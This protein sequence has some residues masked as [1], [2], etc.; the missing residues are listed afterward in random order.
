M[1]GATEI[2]TAP[3]ALQRPDTSRPGPWDNDVFVYRA[4]KNGT[5]SRLATFPRAGVPTVARMKDG[6]L[7]A[8]HQYFPETGEGFDKVAVHFSADE[9]KTWTAART[10]G[11]TGLPEGMRPPFDPTLLPLPDG[12]I[13]LYFTSTRGRGPNAGMPAIYSAISKDGTDYA[14]EP[15][16][17]FAIEGRP[18]IDCAVVLHKGKFHLYSPD[19]GAGAPPGSGPAF[20]IPEAKAREGYGY[21]ALSTDGLTFARQPDVHIDGN[22]AW[23]GCAQ[24]DGDLIGFFGTGRGGLWFGTSSQGG[25]WTLGTFNL[26]IRGA[27]PGA[28]KLSEGVWLFVVTG[29]PRTGRQATER[30]ER[31]L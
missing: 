8:A 2:G 22:G 5:V 16:A 18:V 15:G 4:E 25:E 14:V 27:D 31:W 19:N 10:I 13:R 9:G 28:V 1:S 26:R 20:G 24:S 7:I 29:P 23:L 12:R 11:L 6:R 21:H 17:R 30:A 3:A